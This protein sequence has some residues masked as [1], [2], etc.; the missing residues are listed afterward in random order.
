MKRKIGFLGRQLLAYGTALSIFLLALVG[1]VYGYVEKAC[2]ENAIVHQEQLTAVTTEQVN[3][4]FNHLMLLAN[5]ISHDSEVIQI[6]D[7]RWYHPVEFG[8][9]Y[10]KDESPERT[11]LLEIFETQNRAKKPAQAMFL[12]NWNGDFLCTEP[13]PEKLAI[14][15]EE[16]SVHGYRGLVNFVFSD[17]YRDHLL[18]YPRPNAFDEE[19]TALYIILIMP[20]R[21]ASDDKIIGHVGIMQPCDE[22]YALLELDDRSGIDA[23]LLDYFMGEKIQQFYPVIESDETVRYGDILADETNYITEAKT[24]YAWTVALVQNQDQ[25]LAP[26]R[27]ALLYLLLGVVALVAVLFVSVYLI[28]RHT[29][30]PILELSC[31]VKQL[32]LDHLTGQ[33][34]TNDA[35]DEVKEL[36]RSIDA[37][38]QRVKSAVAL[39][40]KAY[41]N[42]LQAQMNPH[43]L[44]NCLSAISSMCTLGQTRNIPKF[45]SRLAALLRYETTYGDKGTTLKDELDCAANYLEL[46][47][48]RYNNDFEYRIEADE[49]LLD[50]PMPRLM[51]QPVLENC[52]EHGFRDVAPPWR[53]AVHTSR[54][55]NRWCISIKDNG[56]G[57]DEETRQKILWQADSLMERP[58]SYSDLQ[59]GGLGLANTILRL[60]LMTDDDLLY[61]ITSNS[62]GTVLTLKGTMN[63]ESPDRGR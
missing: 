56:C 26:Y 18:L 7:E 50:L 57:M 41:L 30:R 35:T 62:N 29:N 20:I 59:I 38:M 42:A 17:P 31:K 14:G 6:L 51:L 48:L 10:F 36:D 27:T 1:V 5:Q 32:D 58:D 19:D 60:R 21:S 22:L 43:F 9:N 49:A 13:T 54:E 40:R 61:D 28:A 15:V 12:F 34:I 52:F 24:D 47:K 45:C 4:Y 11:R 53:I 23:Y 16:F 33:P 63:H 37:M 3:S 25:L 8:S 39:E 44:Y 46:M 2:R 55:N